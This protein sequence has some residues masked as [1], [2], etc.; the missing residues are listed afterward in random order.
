MMIRPLCIPK[1][2][3]QLQCGHADKQVILGLIPSKSFKWTNSFGPK[4]HTIIA[5]SAET[6]TILSLPANVTPTTSEELV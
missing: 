3:N 6:L 4:R 1:A 2:T 5:P